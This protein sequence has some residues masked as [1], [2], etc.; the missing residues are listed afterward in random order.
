ML[1]VQ[2][3]LKVEAAP[4]E[5]KLSG[6]AGNDYIN[7]FPSA[8]PIEDAIIRDRSFGAGVKGHIGLKM[9]VLLRMLNPMRDKNEHKYRGGEGNLGTCDHD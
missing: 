4:E 9:L 2:Q 7:N 3:Q 6:N 5:H 8:M 1:V